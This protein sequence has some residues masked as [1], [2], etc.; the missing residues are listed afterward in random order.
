MKIQTLN[1]QIAARVLFHTFPARRGAS[2]KCEAHPPQHLGRFQTSKSKLK[3]ISKFDF[4]A[5]RWTQATLAPTIP[6]PPL[7]SSPPGVQVAA[8]LSP[9]GP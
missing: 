4:T 7:P 1:S 6:L 5:S 9:H 3:I 2:Y 8:A